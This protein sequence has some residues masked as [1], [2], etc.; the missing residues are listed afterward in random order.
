MVCGK[1]FDIRP[2]ERPVTFNR[3]LRCGFYCRPVKDPDKTGRGRAE[4]QYPEVQPCEVCGK[5]GRGRGVIDRHHRDS[6][7]MN[8]EPE[9]IA[10]LCR[11]HHNAAH[12]A[13][14]GRIGGGPRPRIVA[15]LHDRATD[16]ART[17]RAMSAA[18]ATTR[19]IATALAVHPSS[20][21]RWFKKYAA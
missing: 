1:A 18:G 4:K 13:T 3:R 12:R 15:L 20:V 9:N 8:N 14:D 17:A 16:M 7:R 21:T 2:G 19:E 5:T 11:R 10:F 6:D